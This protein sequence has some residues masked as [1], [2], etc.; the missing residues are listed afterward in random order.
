MTKKKH[1]KIKENIYA[2]WN[3][4][5]DL[6]LRNP[7]MAELNEKYPDHFLLKGLYPE[8]ASDSHEFDKRFAE[9]YG[10]I[11]PTFPFPVLQ[12]NEKDIKTP[13]ALVLRIDLNF[14]IEEL[15]SDVEDTIKIAR[16]NYLQNRTIKRER[17]SPKKW[18]EYFEIWDIRDGYAPWL[19]DSEGYPMGP[20][21]KKLKRKLTFEEIAKIKDPD[22]LS[23]ENLKKAIDKAKKQYRAASIFIC[24]KKYN[25]KKINKKKNDADKLCPECEFRE[26]C[27]DL[28]PAMVRHL[29]DIEVSQQHKL[30]NNPGMADIEKYKMPG[31]KA[32]SADNQFK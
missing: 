9:I 18:L 30:V 28:C 14:T 10:D 6:V 24:G 15:M 11:F 13:S 23:P 19:R 27:E 3:L 31:K 20:S 5:H 8:D 12:L 16:N 2:Q 22:A 26:D 4:A 25:A 7:W 29:K 17:K 21:M 32:P 1:A